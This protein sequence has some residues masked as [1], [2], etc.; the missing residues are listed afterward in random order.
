MLRRFRQSF[1]LVVPNLHNSKD[2]G[3][4]LCT[5]RHV[6]R[7]RYLGNFI[8]REPTS[9]VGLPTND[10]TA[11]GLRHDHVTEPAL[12]SFQT[13]YTHPLGLPSSKTLRNSRCNILA[14]VQIGNR[15][16]YDKRNNRGLPSF[17][18]MF[19]SNSVRY[20]VVI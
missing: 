7:G 14:V 8:N 2:P 19:L 12:P 1:R 11:W 13:G 5:E 18:R 3:I 9:C 10:T 20:L 16:P 15:W 6:T 4:S 17:L